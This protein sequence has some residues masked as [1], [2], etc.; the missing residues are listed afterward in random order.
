MNI[1]NNWVKIN[2]NVCMVNFDQLNYI[3][4]RGNSVDF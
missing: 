4:N 1:L 2:F 3:Q